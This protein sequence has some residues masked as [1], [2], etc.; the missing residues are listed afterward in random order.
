VLIFITSPDDRRIH[1]ESN[2]L[3]PYLREK[4]KCEIVCLPLDAGHRISVK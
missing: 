3:K 1:M 2:T 4:I